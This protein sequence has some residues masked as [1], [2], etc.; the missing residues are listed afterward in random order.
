MAAITHEPKNIKTSD[1]IMLNTYGSIHDALKM[2]YAAEKDEAERSEQSTDK[3]EGKLKMLS[4]IQEETGNV[5]VITVIGEEY[6]PFCIA[7]EDLKKKLISINKD[8]SAQIRNVQLFSEGVVLDAGEVE[9]KVDAFVEFSEKCG[10]KFN[11]GE[12]DSAEEFS[13]F[14]K[15]FRNKRE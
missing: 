9:G 3:A 6:R 1:T 14:V 8:L 13:N 12:V 7:K 10:I 4:Q 15:V 11:K 2:I 5:Q